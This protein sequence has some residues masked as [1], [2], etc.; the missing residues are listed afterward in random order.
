M[1]LQ[2]M[3]DVDTS[4]SDHTRMELSCPPAHPASMR[5]RSPRPISLPG[6][7][8]GGTGGGIG[9]P[10]LKRGIPPGMSIPGMKTEVRII[11]I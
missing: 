6:V 10:P 1:M 11:F 4:D 9:K 3:T 8:S 2:A 5:P 7:G